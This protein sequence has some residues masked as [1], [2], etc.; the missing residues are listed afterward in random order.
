MPALLSTL[1]L[2]P[3]EG[4]RHASFIASLFRDFQFLLHIQDRARRDRS[5]QRARASKVFRGSARNPQR[6]TKGLIAR[7]MRRLACHA[8]ILNLLIWPSPALTLR[9]IIDPVTATAVKATASTVSALRD[10]SMVSIPIG[11]F[12]LP[13]PIFPSWPFQTSTPIARELSM[14]ERTA[15]V[16]T[17]KI[18]P[19]KLVGYVGDSVTFVAMGAD[20]QGQPTHG[21]KFNWESSDTSKLTIDEAGRANLL[22]PGLVQVIAHAGVAS[23]TA[24]VLIRP[25]RH[26]LQ[27]DDEWRADQDS[28]VGDNGQPSDDGNVGLMSKV[29]NRIVPTAYAQ[30]GQGSDYGNA[31]Y[32]GQ[33]GTPPFTALEDTR[34]GPVMPQNNFELPIPLVNL[35]GRGLAT[36]LTAYYNSNVWGAYFDPIRNGTVYV[37]DPIQGWPGPGIS[38]GFGRIVY[39]NFDGTNYTYMLIDPN[40]TRHLLGTG[41]ALT[42]STLQTTDGTHITFVGNAVNGGIL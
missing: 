32:P 35:G 29:M 23:Q 28:L 18:S 3:F 37:F 30:S 36:S 12:V 2:H 7:P 22:N 14:A 10:L 20:I 31:T 33:V 13:L 24:L 15:K 41:P 26:P 11:P 40:G 42:N 6:R 34:L 8:I 16:A 9:P 39:Y 4:G 17:V 38:L 25:T 27:T 1:S 19:Q 5:L 21:A